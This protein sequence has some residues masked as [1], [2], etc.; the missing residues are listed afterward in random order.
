MQSKRFSFFSEAFILL[1]NTRRR[2]SS[3]SQP[4]VL[5]A[6]W[7]VV[8]LVSV[9]GQQLVS[10]SR[11]YE[12]E[13]CVPLCLGIQIFQLYHSD[14]ARNNPVGRNF[15]SAVQ[16]RALCDTYLHASCL[17]PLLW[18]NKANNNKRHMSTSHFSPTEQMERC[19]SRMRCHSWLQI[20]AKV[21]ER[22]REQG[23]WLR[24]ASGYSL[25]VVSFRSGLRYSIKLWSVMRVCSSKL[26]LASTFPWCCRLSVSRATL[27]LQV[28][29][30][31]LRFQNKSTKN[32]PRSPCG[33]ET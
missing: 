23:G 33:L 16:Q 9:V 8:S 11:L 14:V 20:P 2:L 19:Q 4:A 32:N 18:A 15:Q 6:N 27:A 25:T 30:Q 22:H 3:I 21:N 12:S 24:L 29:V 17:Y 7:Y 10:W 26:A 28:P 5:Q 13:W 1:T 31:A